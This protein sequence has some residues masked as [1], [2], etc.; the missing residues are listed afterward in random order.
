MVGVVIGSL[1]VLCLTS[2]LLFRMTRRYSGNV[3]VAFFVSAVAIAGSAVHWLARPHLFT[4]FL[5]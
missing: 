5:A 2:A 1:S 3:L 4:L